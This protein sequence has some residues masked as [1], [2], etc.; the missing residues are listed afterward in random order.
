MTSLNHSRR[1]RLNVW[2]LKLSRR[3]LR[4]ALV[5]IG[6]FAGLPWVA[7]TLMH[8]GI[9][10][11]AHVLYFVYGPF[12]HQFAFRSFFL[13]GA[14]PDYPRAISGTTLTPYEDYIS[15]SP[16]FR[17]ALTNW[18]GRPESYFDSVDQFDPYLWTFDLQ[19]ASKDFFGT[20]QMGYSWRSRAISRSIRRCSS[21]V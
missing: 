21:A 12:C 20:P 11:P 5:L 3:W 18:V 17:Q 2:L 6:L 13:F 15:N 19:F 10:G 14:Q 7:P 4:V 9:T 8:F 16:E 1:V